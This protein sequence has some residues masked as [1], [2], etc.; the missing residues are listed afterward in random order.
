MSSPFGTDLSLRNFTGVAPLFP[1]P[2]G[3]LLPQL[4]QPLHIFE[5]RYRAMTAAALEGAEDPPRPAR[6]TERLTVSR[7]RS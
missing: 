7:S 6:S 4:V 5:E 1:L 2:S 3:L